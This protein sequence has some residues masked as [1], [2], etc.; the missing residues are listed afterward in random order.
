MNAFAGLNSHAADKLNSYPPDI[1]HP[2]S[3]TF[4][5]DGFLCDAPARGL[6]DFLIMLLC[7]YG[8]FHAG[9]IN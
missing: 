8:Q 3:K 4:D 5:W 9:D 1:I 7:R 2:H 6:G